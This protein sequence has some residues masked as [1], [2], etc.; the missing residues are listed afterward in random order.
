M[1]NFSY[2]TSKFL[3]ITLISLVLL[4]PVFLLVVF[5]M[6]HTS[7][8][9]FSPDDF[10]RRRFSYN[11]VP[12]FK[13][14]LIGKEFVDTTPA[15][16]Q[17]MLSNGLIPPV[18]NNPQN[19]HL[20]SDSGSSLSE[21]ESHDCDARFLV[22]YLDLLNEEGKSY[23]DS[24][25]DKHPLTAKIFWPIVAD[26][27]RHEMYLAIP[28]IMRSAMSFESDD[29]ESFQFMI[30]SLAAQAYLDLATIDQQENRNDRAVE[31]LT[32]SLEIKPTKAAYLLRADVLESTGKTPAALEDRDAADKLV[33][34]TE[35]TRIE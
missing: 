12:F 6:G 17:V 16:E 1:S 23:W 28:D 15:L 33:D 26:L 22:G 34:E 30:D 9:E 7:G 21:Y 4:T 31:R 20:S 8:E 2:R 35:P 18:S 3:K 32:R 27:A 29:A 11:R 13:W 14:T 25:N 19:W 24:W 10:S 5:G